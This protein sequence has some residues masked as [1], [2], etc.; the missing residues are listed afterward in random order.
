MDKSGQRTGLNL[1]HFH[2]PSSFKGVVIEEDETGARGIGIAS[3]GPHSI[4]LLSDQSWRLHGLR[5]CETKSVAKTIVIN[6]CR[7]VLPPGIRSTSL[8]SA[9]QEMPDFLDQCNALVKQDFEAAAAKGGLNEME[10]WSPGKPHKSDQHRQQK[11]PIGHFVE[12]LHTQAFQ[13]H[14]VLRTEYSAYQFLEFL[15]LS[16]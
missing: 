16:A 14:P 9:Y 1:L 13:S 5:L 3:I 11:Q 2:R 4:L 6:S 15:L 12:S 8:C 7:V 10:I